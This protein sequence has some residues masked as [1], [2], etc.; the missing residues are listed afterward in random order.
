MGRR[1]KKDKTTLYVLVGLV[2]LS[3][4]ATIGLSAVLLWPN[5]KKPPTK[6]VQQPQP[7]EKAIDPI[8]P[9]SN[10]VTP[11][12]REGDLFG[13][14]RQAVR[15]GKTSKSVPI[16]GGSREFLDVPD[17]GAILIGLE[18]G[19]GKWSNQDVVH[20][21][22][23]IYLCRRGRIL[24]ARHGAKQERTVTLE[25]KPGYAIGAM[26]IRAGAGLDA[27]AVTFMAIDGDRLNPDRA[28]ESESA[29][30]PGGAE[31]SLSG[32]GAPIVGLFGKLH[33]TDDVTNGLGLVFFNR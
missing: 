1:R 15:A 13:T 4:T 10:P 17:E 18:V 12:R 29:G 8:D 6:T 26:T 19:I 11:P 14:I 9:P 22:T 28:Y 31:Q 21:L 30:G 20:S 3:L 33:P 32:D 7:A 2:A 23:P 24:G 16:G 25:A 5:I 27:V